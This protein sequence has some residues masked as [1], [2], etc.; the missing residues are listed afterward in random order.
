MPPT[1]RPRLAGLSGS[2]GAIADYLVDQVVAQQPPAITKFLL[3]TSILN[4]F[5]A[6]LCERR[7]RRHR[8]RRRQRRALSAT[9][10]ACIE[11][12]EHANLFVIPLDNEREW[13]RYHHL[14]QELLQRRLRVEVGPGAGEPNSTGPPQPGLPPKDCS[15]KRCAMRWPSTTSTW[16]R[17]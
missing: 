3:L 4:R 6:P 1:S 2:N 14:F 5:C 16:P 10:P 13:Y 17:S 8:C 9:S 11:W 12:L 7:P 15:T